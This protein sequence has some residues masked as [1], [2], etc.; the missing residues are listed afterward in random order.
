MRSSKN[1]TESIK[2]W[3]IYTPLARMMNNDDLNTEPE[4]TSV[5]PKYLEHGHTFLSCD[6]IHGHVE[7]NMIRMM[8]LHNFSDIVSPVQTSGG[9][10][11]TIELG[12]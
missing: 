9:G 3:F 4:V 8:N 11:K 2:N 1:S 5:T 7:E 6:S 12:L 10:P